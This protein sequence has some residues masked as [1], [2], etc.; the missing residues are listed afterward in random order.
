MP[1][2]ATDSEGTPSVA[3]LLLARSADDHPGLL[4]GDRGWSW[5]E[6]VAAGAERAALLGSLGPSDPPHV[7]VLLGNEPEYAFWLTAR[8]S[9]APS[10]S[11]ST[12]PGGARRSPATSAGPTAASS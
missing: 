5:R 8:R 2:E 12:P 11:G 4:A 10:S 6:V 7:G 1:A 3:D 9:R